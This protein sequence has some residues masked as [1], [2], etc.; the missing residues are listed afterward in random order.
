MTIHMMDTV[1][2]NRV[3]DKGDY[4]SVKIKRYTV[5]TAGGMKKNDFIV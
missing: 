3:D 2:L 1:L 5:T 4:S